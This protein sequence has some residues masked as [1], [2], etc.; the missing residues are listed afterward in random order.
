M[1]NPAYTKF[2]PYGKTLTIYIRKSNL[3]EHKSNI[4]LYDQY[5]HRQIDAVYIYTCIY[6]HIYI[7]IYVYIYIYILITQSDLPGKTYTHIHHIQTSL[8]IYYF[9]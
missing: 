5:K 9:W 7:Y 8:K 1:Y 3:S 2:V 4:C 6:K